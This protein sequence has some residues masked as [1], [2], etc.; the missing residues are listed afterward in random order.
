M[1]QPLQRIM[2][3]VLDQDFKADVEAVADLI[4]SE[5][6]VK[7]IE[8]IDDTSDLLVKSVKPNFKVLGPKYGK[9]MKH[10]VKAINGLDKKD[11][12]KLEKDKQID[13]KYQW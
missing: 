9:D 2:I 1:R 4:K 13:I 7:A 10:A 5:V 8:F 3:P 11:I 12:A 6:N